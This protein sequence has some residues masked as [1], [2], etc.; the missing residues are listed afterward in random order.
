MKSGSYRFLRTE[1]DAVT[2]SAFE[3]ALDA[4]L[5]DKSGP[6]RHVACL[7]AYCVTLAL[8]DDRLARIIIG[9]T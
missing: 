9:P 2:Y 6:S 3:N 7:N 8:K 1:I 5:T 4:W